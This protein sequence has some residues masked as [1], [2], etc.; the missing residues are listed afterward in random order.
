MR[1]R[2]TAVLLAV[3]FSFW[4][5]LTYAATQPAYEIIS[6]LDASYRLTCKLYGT[7]GNLPA[8]HEEF[9]STLCD[10]YGCEHASELHDRLSVA[11]YSKLHLDQQPEFIGLYGEQF[12]DSAASTVKVVLLAAAYHFAGTGELSLEAELKGA[13]LEQHCQ[14]MITQSNN[15]SANIVLSE[16]GYMRIN[17]WLKQLGFSHDELSFGRFFKPTRFDIPSSDTENYATALALAQFYFLLAQNDDVPGFL[18]LSSINHI[19]QIIS[20]TNH[21][22]NPNYNDRLNRKFSASEAVFYHKTGAN[23]Q[24]VGD[25]GIFSI[26]TGSSS[27]K[28]IVVVFDNE[29]DRKLMGELGFRISQLMLEY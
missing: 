11:I 19:R 17:N 1:F 24:V 10:V 21:N 3:A 7:G 18:S 6:Q 28:Y 20:S 12:R 25:G 4:A 16:I 8:I 2:L 13:S 23:S 27:A 14:Q 9:L 5:Q 15:D 26:S 29:K 22:S